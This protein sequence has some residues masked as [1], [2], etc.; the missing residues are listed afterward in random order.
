[1]SPGE[2]MT[3]LESTAHGKAWRQFCAANKP[4]FDA[5]TLASG[6]QKADEFLENRLRRTF[7][8]A[9]RAGLA[10]GKQQ[11]VHRLAEVILKEGE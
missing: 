3:A 2:P 1:M 8:E 5:A 4:A 11:A 6:D 10:A 7:T 9:F